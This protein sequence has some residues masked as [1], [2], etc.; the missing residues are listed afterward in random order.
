MRIDSTSSFNLMTLPPPPSSSSSTSS[1]SYSSALLNL[2]FSRRRK[3]QRVKAI[4]G[5]EKE[6]ILVIMGATGCG[7]SGLSVQLA[8]HFQ[9]EIINCDKMQVY[10]GLDI[11]TNKIPLHERHDVPHH[12]LGDVDSLH[13]EFTPFHFRLRADNVVSD[14]CSRNKLPILVGG[15]NS[16]IHAMLV[17]HFNPMDD[18]FLTHSHIPKSLISSDLRYRCC[19]LWLDVSFPILSEYL[20]IRVDEMLQLGMFEELAEFYHPDTAETTPYTG[21]RKAIGVP[22]FDNYFKKYPPGQ[23]NGINREA[24]EEAVDAIK[25][26]THVLAERQIGKILKLKGAGWDIHVLNATEAF[27]AVVQPGTGRNRKQIWEK[28][29]LKP[30]LR[31]VKRFLE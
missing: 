29:I 10:K 6:K 16:F 11:T 13:E 14:I 30:S 31:I 28:Q 23:K 20:S 8:S 15:S 26:N 5:G 24:F 27:R 18:V 2:P 12:L 22:E 17:N 25:R 19:F 4:A 7:K 3:W 1:S 21:I 9:S